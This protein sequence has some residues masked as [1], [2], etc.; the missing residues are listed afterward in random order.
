MITSSKCLDAHIFLG[1]ISRGSPDAENHSK[2][3][4]CSESH[5]CKFQITYRHGKM[6]SRLLCITNSSLNLAAIRCTVKKRIK[7]FYDIESNITSTTNV[8]LKYGGSFRKLKSTQDIEGIVEKH[9]LEIPIFRVFIKEPEQCKTHLEYLGINASEIRS[10]NPFYEDGHESFQ[11]DFEGAQ[12]FSSTIESSW[13]VRDMVWAARK[14]WEEK[15][16]R[17]MAKSWTITLYLIQPGPEGEEE[18]YLLSKGGTGYLT[19]PDGFS[20]SLRVVVQENDLVL[21]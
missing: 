4:D 18:A 21:K 1:L 6:T 9:N 12:I 13:Y 5:A 3:N 8:Q 7:E 11:V 14:C 19:M 17:T 10:F 16:G 2:A 20:P 15:L